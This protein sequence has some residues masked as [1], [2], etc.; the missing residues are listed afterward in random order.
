MRRNNKTSLA[1]III[2]INNILTRINKLVLKRPR[3]VLND[4][5]FLVAKSD[6]DKG[7]QIQSLTT[8]V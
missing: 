1:S 3:R 8:T 2:I 5:R 4:S 7:K 6:N